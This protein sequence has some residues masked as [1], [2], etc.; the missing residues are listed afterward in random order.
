[1][2]NQVIRTSK[3]KKIFFQAY[4]TVAS[5]IEKFHL[6]ERAQVFIVIPDL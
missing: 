2:C 4:T 5:Y 6:D 3:Q 1:M